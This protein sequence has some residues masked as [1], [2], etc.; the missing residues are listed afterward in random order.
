MDM[1]IIRSVEMA[2]GRTLVDRQ[3]RR[4]ALAHG[5]LGLVILVQNGA[6]PGEHRA[7]STIRTISFVMDD[8][9]HRF[10]RDETGI[11]CIYHVLSRAQLL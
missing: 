10:W 2:R 11:S 3:D 4:D 8:E 6:E 7:I 1:H 9:R 5:T